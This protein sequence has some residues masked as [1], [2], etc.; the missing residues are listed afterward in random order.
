MM[1]KSAAALFAV[2]VVFAAG[3][4]IAEDAKTKPGV[5]GT[6][7]SIDPVTR[8]VVLDGGRTYHMRGDADVSMV[9]K[10]ASAALACDT[11]GAN[12]IVITAGPPNDAVPE[13]QTSPGA[14]NNTGQSSN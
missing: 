11:K 3:A 13:S 7:E 8:M 5:T 12:C 1:I 10:G 6:V 4:A 14:G 2:L 9:S